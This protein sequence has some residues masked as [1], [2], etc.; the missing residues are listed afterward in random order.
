MSFGR[1]ARMPT[2]EEETRQRFRDWYGR[3][4]GGV[5]AEIE[6]EVIGADYGATGY[7]TRAQ[8]DDIAL[9]LGLRQGTRVLD[10]GT[11]RGWPAVYFAAAYG[12]DVVASDIPIEGLGVG[13]RR[14]RRDDLDHLVRFVAASGDALPLAGEPFDAVVHTDTL[15]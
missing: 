5:F 8:V 10:I 2:G 15:C 6:R 7:T 14:A 11:G 4:Y 3:E 13:R 9:R 12:C 1:E